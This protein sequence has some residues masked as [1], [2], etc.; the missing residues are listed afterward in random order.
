M[1]MTTYF[2]NIITYKIKKEENI[3]N[4]TRKDFK[5]SDVIVKKFILYAF[6]FY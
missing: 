5:L 6:Y 1:I 3:L 4:F 2:D